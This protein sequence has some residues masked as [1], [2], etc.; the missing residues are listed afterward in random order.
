MAVPEAPQT[1]QNHWIEEVP[2]RTKACAAKHGAA[3][4]LGW[5]R[6]RAAGGAQRSAHAAAV[7]V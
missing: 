1:V 3:K 6:A 4:N 2:D 5:M 7:N